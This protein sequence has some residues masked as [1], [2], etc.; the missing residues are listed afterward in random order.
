[1]LELRKLAETDATLTLGWDPPPDVHAYVFYAE[2][3]RVTQGTP[4]YEKDMPSIGKK[5]GDPRDQVKY[6]K[7]SE[8]YEVAALCRNAAGEFRVEVGRYPATPPPSGTPLDD[9][10]DFRNNIGAIF[11]NRWAGGGYQPLSQTAPNWPSINGPAI[12]EV[13]TPHGQG[14][15]FDVRAEMRHSDPDTKSAMMNDE[16]HMCPDAFPAAEGAL[17]D[18]RFK[19]MLP[20]AG[21]PSFADYGDW[22]MLMEFH[23]HGPFDVWHQLGVDAVNLPRRLYFRCYDPAAPGQ[24]RKAWHNQPLELD[25]WYDVRWR[26]RFSQGQSGYVQAWIDGYQLLD[27]SGPTHPPASGGTQPKVHPHFG[28]YSG[29]ASAYPRN[30]A[31]FAGMSFAT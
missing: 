16:N 3:Q 23:P 8:L 21:N 1:V 22:N 24:V 14:F 26:W 19:V 5:K 15:R 12:T 10:D 30:E 11:I 18:L 25:H 6:A 2:G 27:Y 4:L 7:G 9:F 29:R 17:L 20:Q 31:I 28:Y 13:Q